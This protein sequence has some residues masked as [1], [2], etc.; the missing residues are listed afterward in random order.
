MSFLIGFLPII[1]IHANRPLCRIFPIYHFCI[2][3]HGRT[4]SKDNGNQTLE[5]VDHHYV[6]SFLNEHLPLK[7]VSFSSRRKFTGAIKVFFENRDGR[8]LNIQ[9]LRLP[10]KKKSLPKVLSLDEVKSL[11]GAVNNQKHHLILF[12]LYCCGLRMGE[13]LS[14]KVE[15]YDP[16]RKLLWILE[17]KKA[18][19][20]RIPLQFG[21][22]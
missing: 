16:K 15:D 1:L 21:L 14:L 9:H 5:K 7:S 19:D 10:K 3:V 18:K 4:L 2:L 6:H 11:I 13:H 8:I 12:L 17:G 20:M 22:V